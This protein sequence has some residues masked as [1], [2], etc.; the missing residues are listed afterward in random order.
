[1]PERTGV[2]RATIT[3]LVDSLERDE[4]VTRTPDPADRRMLAVRLTPKGERVLFEVL[5]KHFRRMAWLLEP[6]SNDERRT[7]VDL[8]AK[9][10]RRAGE[11]PIPAVSVAPAEPTHA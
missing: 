11:A 5:P 9:I 2:T 3:G 7:M 10:I 8:M 6:L 4:L 1:M